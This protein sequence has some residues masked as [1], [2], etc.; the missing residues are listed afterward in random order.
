MAEVKIEKLKVEDL[1][2]LSEVYADAFTQADIGEIWTAEQAE[3]FMRYWVKRTN[4]LFF[5]AKID[6]KIVGGVV[7]DV[8]PFCGENW[9]IDIELF[10]HPDYQKQGIGK[11]LFKKILEEA[12]TRDNIA[13]A[14]FVSDASNDF[15]MNWYKKIGMQPMRWVYLKGYIEDLLKNLE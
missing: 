8:R 10:V 2:K 4:D 3:N 1:P 14:G 9:L 15:P 12:K 11:K 7:G 13:G 5:T 6:D